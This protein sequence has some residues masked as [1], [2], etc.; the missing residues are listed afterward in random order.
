MSAKATNSIVTL[1]EESD[2]IAER[3]QPVTNLHRSSYSKQIS[4]SCTFHLELET[5]GDYSF[6]AKYGSF[7]SES[8]EIHIKGDRWNNQVYEYEVEN[9]D[10]FN[11]ELSIS[12]YFETVNRITE[13]L[14]TTNAARSIFIYN[15]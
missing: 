4:G 10:N 15:V 5:P 2:L 6:K 9:G 7:E 14:R 3:S 11:V 1:V 12:D 8:L 13:S